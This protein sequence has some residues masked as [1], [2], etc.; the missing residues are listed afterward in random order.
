MAERATQIC[1]AVAAFV[2]LASGTVYL[3]LGSWP[4]PAPDFW[5][6]Y[7]FCLNHTWLESALLKH[8]GHSLFFPSFIWLTDLRFFHGNQQL[9]FYVGLTLLLIATGLLLIPVWRDETV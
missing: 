8:N 5:I 2:F 4:V 1:A 3:Y 7:D 6:I 9:V